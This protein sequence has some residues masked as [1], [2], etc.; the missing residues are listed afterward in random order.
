MNPNVGVCIGFGSFCPNLREI[1][2]QT[3]DEKIEKLKENLIE[4]KKRGAE[5]VEFSVGMVFPTEDETNFN[6]LK[7]A[8][9]SSP[10]GKVMAYN[11]F[12]P[13]NIKI[14]GNEANR[15]KIDEYLATSIKRVSETG[16]KII[17]FG[18]GRARTIPD[19]F[20]RFEAKKQIIEFLKMCNYYCRKYD[21]KIAIEPLNRTES[22]IINTVE[23]GLFYVNELNSEYIGVLCD[24]YHMW[25]ENENPKIF[26]EAGR[27]LIHIHISNSRR[28][29]PVDEEEKFIPFFKALKDINYS[30]LISIEAGFKD[31]M[32]ELP[33][34]IKFVQEVYSKA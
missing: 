1:G 11:S 14:T 12:I 30:G 13:I 21:V 6:K 5:F 19:G 27:R 17:V 25:L 3:A 15:E 18:S 16:S 32:Q 22:N 28:L 26:E 10:F 9:I 33:V 24:C 2:G 29:P 7:T 31:L 34:A 8:V 20:S 23:E 4:V